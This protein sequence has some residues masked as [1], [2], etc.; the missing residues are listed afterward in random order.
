M[1][2]YELVYKEIRKFQKDISIN[3]YFSVDD[4]LTLLKK[5]PK[6]LCYLSSFSVTPGNTTYLSF[7]Y[8]N[9][10][11]PF[12]T[13]FITNSL[14]EMERIFYLFLK[15]YDEKLTFIVKNMED[16]NKFLTF[17]ETGKFDDFP[18][19]KALNYGGSY[20]F[21]G[22]DY[23]VVNLEVTY[24]VNPAVLKRME[25]EINNEVSR[26]ASMLF[27]KDM[28]KEVKIL[29]AHN[30]LAYIATYDPA[31]LRQGI[32]AFNPY[33]H[34]AY[35]ALISKVCVCHGFA[36]AFK[37]ILNRG[38]VP[39][40]I[41]SGTV[42]RNGERHAWNYVKLDDGSC[43]HVDVTFDDQDKIIFDYFMKSDAVMR[44]D[45]T[46]PKEDCPNCDGNDNY[47]KIIWK[48]ITSNKTKLVLKGIKLPVLNIN[49]Y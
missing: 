34:S 25:V 31:Y 12:E 22:V 42:K 36:E 5:Y 2:K 20:S 39:C 44:N 8:F 1:D 45:R 9:T 11:I 23:T 33:S 43:Y 27:E 29:L 35:G 6:L 17:P 48:Y 24:H 37:R 16:F 26:V 15:R 41:V 47:K 13:I 18:Y 7:E 30:Y 32:S 46:W 19:L 14:E 4:M 21:T 38:G 40:E 28:P 3:E 10:N 49:F